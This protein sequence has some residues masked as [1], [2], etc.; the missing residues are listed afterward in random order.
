MSNMLSGPRVHLNYKVEKVKS[1]ASLLQLG[2]MPLK[3]TSAPDLGCVF[4][5]NMSLTEGRTMSQQEE[6]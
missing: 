4:H 5:K 1:R 3:Y 2:L 6:H